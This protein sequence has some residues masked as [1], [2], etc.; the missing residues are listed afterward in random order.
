MPQGIKLASN[1]FQRTTDKI[2]YDLQDCVLPCFYDDINI[3]GNTF[4]EH[5]SN[6][7]RVLPQRI[8][9]STF[10]LIALECKFFLLQIPYLGYIFDNRKILPDPDPGY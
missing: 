2:F 6:V 5:L 1:T 4:T 8:R 3:K 10:T 9:D 7:S